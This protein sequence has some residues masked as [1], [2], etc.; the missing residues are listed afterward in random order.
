M[1]TGDVPKV[2]PSTVS[3]LES[4]RTRRAK[5][6]RK[7][8]RDQRTSADRRAG[9]VRARGQL[10]SCAC[11]H[12]SLLSWAP[13]PPPVPHTAGTPVMPPTPKNREDVSDVASRDE[14]EARLQQT[15]SRNTRTE[16]CPL[17]NLYHEEGY[18]D[19]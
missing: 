15:A 19:I 14:K 16:E 8:S 3:V 2:T 6:Q 10:S 5:S 12:L 18:E 1:C 4:L 13:S 17:L 11:F 9:G 7:D